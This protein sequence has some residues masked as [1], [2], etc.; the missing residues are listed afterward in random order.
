MPYINAT[1]VF[2]NW[3][4][5]LRL[6]AGMGRTNDKPI[7]C[8]PVSGREPPMKSLL[9]SLEI[10]EAVAEHQP[11]SVGE[12][13]KRLALPKST[14]QRVLLTFHE[15]GWLRQ[16]RGDMTRWEIGSRVLGVR[17]P[18][19]NGGRLYAAARE[20]MRALRDATNETVHLSIP[21]GINNVVLIDRADC[22]QNVRTFSP[23]GDAAPFHATANGMAIMAW[24]EPS[25][26]EA[27]IA[28][29]LPGFTEHTITRADRLREELRAVRER[30]YSLN[31]S[32]Y[33]PAICAIGAAILDAER[34]PVGSVCISMPQ[35][36]Y[37][38]EKLAQWGRQVA[39]AA[40][41]IS[42]QQPFD[43]I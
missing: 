10:L 28:R 39:E 8:A 13:A 40:H 41:R 23:L 30:G 33:R 38:P 7:H 5:L 14:V 37:Q 29:G 24:L 31:L 15:A 16:R 1:P 42:M 4:L 9:K 36:R 43:P 11:V 6:K 25:E 12:L 17:P 2:H 32:H 21:D 35:S 20:P 27:I 19:L 18:E 34:R 22:D 3:Q 26:I